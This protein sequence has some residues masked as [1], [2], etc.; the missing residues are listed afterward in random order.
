MLAAPGEMGGEPGQ[1]VVRMAKHVGAGALP[2]LDAIDERA[3][4]YFVQVGRGGARDRLAEHATGGKE[5]VRYQSWRTQALPVQIAIIHNL[6]C[7][8]IGLDSLR[9]LYSLLGIKDQLRGQAQ[10]ASRARGR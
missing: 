3:A 9:D 2:G 8:Q 1:G 5:I 4:D 10:A 6:D 7:R